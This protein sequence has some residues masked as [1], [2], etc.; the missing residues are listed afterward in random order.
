ME[1]TIQP[2]EPT[3]PRRTASAL[4]FLI[5]F[6]DL[7]GVGLIVPLSP[8]IVERFDASAMAVGWLA[9]SYSAAQFLATPIL[10]VLSDR[11]GRR[12]VLI[13]SLF[14]SAVGYV[15]FALANA[16]PILFAARALDGATGGNISTAQAYI[17][18]ITPP[19][20]RAKAYGLVGAAFGL[21][22]TLGPAISAL[23]TKTISMM[24]P[25]WAAAGLSLVTMTLVYFFL[26]E[27]HPPAK[28]RLERVGVRDL[29]P[30]RSL[31]GV[32]R[33]PA[34][35]WLLLAVFFFNFAHAELR[36]AFGVLLR[37]KLSYTEDAAS[38]MFAYMGLMAVLVQGGLVR[39]L[40]PV[41]GDWRTAMI[42]LPLAALGYA[43]MPAWGTTLGVAVALTVLAL[44]GGLAGPTITS[45]LSGAADA[46]AQGVAMGASQSV[47]AL[48]LVIG[49]LFAGNLY[50]R[51]GQGWPFW[52]GAGFVLAT[53][54]I[55]ALRGPRTRTVARSRPPE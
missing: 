7:L 43:L 45:M 42:G 16:L 4:I 13:W 30:F 54:L 29:N 40:T 33:V 41:L 39:R 5:V 35:A 31:I 36:T 26:P 19:A 46:E 53:L 37:D 48:A 49:P 11:F 6:L 28:R 32:A 10:G 52:T 25:V 24:A 51:A 9:M 3:A 44:G 34:V 27:S 50:D 55:I 8:Y 2:A 18:D 14:G 23:L 38:W 15:V 1:P 47:S 22:F 17:A 21:G 20:Q 12:P